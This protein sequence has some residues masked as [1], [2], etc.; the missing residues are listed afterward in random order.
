M[1]SNYQDVRQTE[2][3]YKPQSLQVKD[4][5]AKKPVCFSPDQSIEEVAEIL[6]KKNISGGPVLTADGTLVGVIS[7]GDCL[8]D[9]VKGMYNNSPKMSEK[10][11]KRMTYKPINVHPGQDIFEVA[12]LFLKLRLRRFPVIENEKLIGQ[13]SQKDILRAMQA[14]NK[15]TWRP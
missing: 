14:L 11:K 9:A 10:V 12:E 2:T 4:F 6:V 7:E 15:E 5:M 13:I 1:V 8:K 3:K